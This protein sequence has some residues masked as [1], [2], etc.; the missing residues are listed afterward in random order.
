MAIDYPSLQSAPRLLLEAELKP[1]QGDRF[2]PTG[3]ADLG[4]ARYKAPNNEEMLLVESAQSV[5][6]RLESVI[7]DDATGDLIPDLKGI[8]YVSIDC[9]EHGKS[10]SL[11]EFH[12]LNSPYLWEGVETDSAVRFRN[13]F[14]ADMGLR[15]SQRRKKKGVKK[16][17][18]DEIPGTFD[19]KKFVTTVF[20]W[21]P[22][23]IIHGLFLE[24]VAGRLRLMRMLSGF[25]EATDV[26]AAESGGTKIDHILPSPKSLGLSADDGFGNVPFHRTEFTAKRIVAYFNLD[27][28]LLRGYGLPEEATKLLIA[29]SL[30]KVRRFLNQGLRLRTACDLDLAGDLTATRPQGFVVP[31]ESDLLADA[32]ARLDAC[33]NID[34]L[35][36][37]PPVTIVTWEAPL[38]GRKTAKPESASGD[39]EDNQDDE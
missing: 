9:G 7:W 35:F 34:G 24:K 21:D 29:L 25:I 12:R 28:A 16:S 15:P 37:E 2:Q 22:N 39:E 20:K 23:S 19:M 36:S 18:E 1:L 30:L 17:D 26:R 3:F 27:L 13:A 5:A 10:N 6:N 38:K 4:A 31:N 8:P 14:M 32:K 11:F 33:A